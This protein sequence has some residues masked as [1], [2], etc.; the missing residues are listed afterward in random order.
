MES[1]DCQKTVAAG[2]GQTG[3]ALRIAPGSHPDLHGSSVQGELG[4]SSSSRSVSGFG[5]GWRTQDPWQ[6][7]YDPR[8]R[9]AHS[10]VGDG[11]ALRIPSRTPSPVGVRAR[12]Y[13]MPAEEGRIT[14]RLGSVAAAFPG[15]AHAYAKAAPVQVSLAQ[16]PLAKAP[17]FAPGSQEAASEDPEVSF[18]EWLEQEEKQTRQKID[19]MEKLLSLQATN[20]ALK[21]AL[22]SRQE[23]EQDAWHSDAPQGSCNDSGEQRLPSLGSLGHPTSCAEPCRYFGKARGCKKDASCDRCHLCEWTKATSKSSGSAE[24]RS[25]WRKPSS[26][27]Q[28]PLQPGAVPLGT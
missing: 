4:F 12:E 13:F 26:K 11:F 28:K 2:D 7:E 24:K 20:K 15:T 14:P 9:A 22:Q 21:S 25:P 10:D 16:A 18:R 19:A 3:N 27:G 23:H 5:R 6:T 1:W 8:G 17:T